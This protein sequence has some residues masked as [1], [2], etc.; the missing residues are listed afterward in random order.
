[1]TSMDFETL[2]QSNG[3]RT[4][5]EG[6][7]HARY[8][9]LQFDCPFCGTNSGKYHMGYD[10]TNKYVNCWNCGH[11]SITETMAVLF[12]ITYVEAKTIAKGIRPE[13]QQLKLHTGQFLKPAEVGS[14]HNAHKRYI[15]SRGFD[16][17]YIAELWSVQGIALSNPAMQW[18]LFLPIFYRGERV[19]WTTRA[20]DEDIRPRY[21]SAK[22]EYE[23]IPHKTLLYGEDFA[24]HAIVIVEGPIDVWAIGPGAVATFGLS[25]TSAQVLKMSKYPIR[26]VCLDNTKQAQD[27]ARKLVDSLSGYKGETYN[28]QLSGKDAAESPSTELERIRKEILT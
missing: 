11:H 24:R 13:H 3:I 27:T 16:W 26:A 9:W 25:I 8:G 2:L 17:R 5:P 20:I 1:M 12:G 10:I 19:S 22:P 18:R 14:L 28:I 23:T 6:H 21:L 15:K 7:H 4:A